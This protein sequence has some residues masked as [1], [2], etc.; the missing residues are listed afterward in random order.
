[1]IRRP[2]AS[3]TL[4][5]LALVS[6]PND[7]RAQI[8]VLE[9]PPPGTVVHVPFTITGWV[10]DPASPDN[11]S[12]IDAVRVDAAA[13]RGRRAAVPGCPHHQPVASRYCRHLRAEGRVLRHLPERRGADPAGP[14][15]L[16]GRCAPHQRRRVFGT[17]AP[18]DCGAWRHD[19]L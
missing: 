16:G 7:A 13:R 3:L 17:G 1:M 19:P 11:T 8:G 12:G 14:I 15:H 4:L 5:M 2:A 9:V 18:P 10:F 6:W